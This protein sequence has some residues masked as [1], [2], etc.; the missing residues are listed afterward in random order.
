MNDV[1]RREN[2]IGDRL[3]HLSQHMSTF[4]SGCPTFLG[5]TP[6]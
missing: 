4:L 3:Q 2:G 1:V 6:S 5:K